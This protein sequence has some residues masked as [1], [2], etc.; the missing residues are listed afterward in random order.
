M[1]EQKMLGKSKI[2]SFRLLHVFSPKTYSLM[3]LCLFCAINMF[4]QNVKVTGRVTDEAEESIIGAAIRVVDGTIGTI[5]DYDGNFVL[6]VPKGATIEVSY[7]GYVPKRIQVTEGKVYT[8]VLKEDTKLLDEVIVTG[9]GAVSKKNLTTSIVKVKADEVNKAATSNMSQMLLGRAAGLQATVAS[10]QPGG[11]INISIRGAG[12]PI[13]VVDG[14]VMPGD[15]LEG[16]SGGSTTVMPSSINRSGLAGLNP[17]DIESIEVLKDASASIYGIGAANGVVLI[18]TKK[19]KEGKVKVTYEGN[20]SL[21][22]NYPYLDMLDAPSYMKYVN[23]FGREQYMHDHNMGAYGSIPYDNGFPDVFSNNDIASAKT[24]NWRDLVLKDGS[25]SKH[26]ITV[27]GGTK[28]LNYYLSGNYIQQF[29]TVSNSEMERFTLRSNVSAQLTSFLK[30]TTAFNINRNI[31]QNGTVGGASNGRGEQASGALAAALSYLPNMPVRDEN[32][33]YTLFKIIPNPVAMED[34]QNE[35]KNNGY[36]INFTVDVDIIKNM[37][38][39]KFLF[40][41]NNENSERNVYIPSDIYFDQMYKSRGAVNRNERYNTTIEGTISFNK[42]FGENFRMDAVVGMGRYLNKYTGLGVSYTDNNDILANDNIGAAAG[43][44]T[45]SSYR[46]ED[47]KRSQF[48]RASFDLFD[49]YVI[50]GTLRRDGTDKFFKGKKYCWFPSV[51]IAWKIFN[52]EFMRDIEW[53]NLLKL[54]ASY[55]VTGND[56]LGSTLYGSYDAFGTHVMFNENS[57][58][59][60]P[61]YLKSQD[62]PDVTWEKTVMKN[63]GL[64]F[65]LLNDRISGSFDYFWND[66]TDM[67]GYANSNGLSMFG[68]YPINGAHIRRYGWDATLNTVNVTT[69]DFKWTSVLTLSHTNAIWKERMPNHT[70]NEYQIRKDEP[71]NARYYYRTN[72][73]V[74]AD[75]SNMPSYQPEAYQKPGCPIIVDLNGDGQITVE[76]VDMKNVIPSIYWG[77]GNTFTYKNWDLDIFIYSQLGVEKYNDIYSWTSGR[78]LGNQ[79]NNMSVYIKD[80]WHS[81]LNPNGT[82]PGIAYEMA[83]VS[84]PGGAGTDIGYENSSFVRVR[85]IT[86]GY[87]FKSNQLGTLSKFISS[88]R[89]YADV[90]NPITITGYTGFDPEVNTGGSYKGGKAE[91]PQTRTFS[92]GAKL[93]F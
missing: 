80:V 17:E 90:Q 88:I 22:K 74:N 49:K 70:Y 46:R 24:T 62:Y 69:K 66:I 12:T 21:V 53:V 60:I 79:T 29:G 6:D 8:I 50:A 19:G 25:I 48:A 9:Y 31:Y 36:N 54:R 43:T 37:L 39:A 23:A 77:L 34:I 71:V 27:Q 92:L 59:Y 28:T 93:S 15:A 55:G 30:L 13:Y 47:E 10:A 91:Y 84:L 75:K 40:G 78:G 89:V 73:L 2:Q 18:T 86:L 68:S 35:S 5:S 20:V 58:K 56:N 14:M 76:D 82:I 3:A 85:N 64:D 26:N 87:N 67:L 16:D 45:P 63:I 1:N 44:F 42:A 52:E 81:E 32:G 83:S 7:V 11:G 41:Y 33:N 57:I 38:A 4:A 65:S 51:S 61:Y 72:G